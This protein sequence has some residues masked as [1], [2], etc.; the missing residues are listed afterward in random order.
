MN[1][2][3]KVREV[4]KRHFLDSMSHL[5]MKLLCKR[6][7]KRNL[8]LQQW[9]LKLQGASNLTLSEIQNGDV[10]EETLRA[11]KVKKSKH[12]T[13]VGLSEA[14]NGDLSHEARENIKVK[15]YPQ[16]SILLT[17][18]EAAMQSPNSESKEKNA[19]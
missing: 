16:K 2:M 9:N 4:E 11:G 12:S 10:S 15:K 19:E 5:P 18:G 7:E 8:K 6:I 17:S 1:Y 14:Q 3:S 13:N